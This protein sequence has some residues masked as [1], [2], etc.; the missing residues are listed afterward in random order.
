MRTHQEEVL[1]RWPNAK[2]TT[3]K[4]KYHIMRDRE[5]GERTILLRVPISGLWETEEKAW[6]DAAR[7]L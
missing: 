7:K 5:P 4:N 1:A 2:A 3:W 6:A